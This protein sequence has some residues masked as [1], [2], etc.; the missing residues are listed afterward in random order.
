MIRSKREFIYITFRPHI[1]KQFSRGYDINNLQPIIRYML[2]SSSMSKCLNGKQ[3]HKLIDFQVLYTRKFTAPMQ[4]LIKPNFVMFIIFLHH[5]PYLASL[6]CWFWNLMLRQCVILYNLI[7]YSGI[8]AFI[9][10]CILWFQVHYFCA[11]Y[12]SLQTLCSIFFS[13]LYLI[14]C[15]IYIFIF[16]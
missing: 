13:L 7:P 3:W 2:L 11:Y 9:I 1:K 10:F 16:F 12:T 8:L 15:N 4:S 6:Q 14:I 5:I